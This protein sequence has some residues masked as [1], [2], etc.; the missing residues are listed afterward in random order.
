[1]ICTTI[2]AE[3]TEDAVKAMKK[4]SKLT[5]LIEL[6]IDYIQDINKKNLK[7]LLNKKNKPIIVTNRK[8]YEMEKFKG[9]EKKRIGL[10]EE[11]IKLKADYIDIEYSANKQLLKK[12]I[13]NKGKTKIIV[14]YHNFKN[15]P[16]NLHDIF[17]KI[18][19]LN[20]DIIKIVAFAN[21]INDNFKIFELLKKTKN[22]KIIAFCMGSYGK[23]SRIL[24]LKYNSFLTYSS[25]EQQKK[26]ESCQLTLNE[27]LN[28]YNTKKINKNTQV[29]GLIGNPLE[30][31]PSHLIHNAG[32]KK[33]K[34]NNI[35]VKFKVDNLN[36]FIKN[37]RKFKIKGASITIPH[38]VAVMKHLDSIDNT[39]KKIGAVNTIVNKN[40]KLK[41]YNTDCYGAITVIKNKTE[42]KNKKI[43]VLGAGGTARAVVYGLTQ[44]KGIITILNRT[45][46]KA[47]KL[48]EEFNC[49]Y[50][51]LNNFKNIETDILVN[52]TSVGMSPD[53]GR[54]LIPKRFLKNMV[55]FDA[56]FNPHKTKL[57]KDSESNNCKVI[58][59]IE[60]LIHQAAIQF[61]LWTNQ[62]M[63]INVMR[64]PIINRLNNE[65]NK[66]DR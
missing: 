7:R 35:Y 56:V 11:S 32:F 65:K 41:G 28:D 27:L 43:T 54:S 22:K 23:I 4:A 49:N 37:F 18:K 20:P 51:S 6:R 63:P 1:M 62:E 21:S 33:L 48:A 58:P 2:V 66:H 34:L 8:K 36:E 44:E 52:T 40:N 26:A 53:I 16:N 12:I 57:I 10:L 30:H 25:Y 60:M 42:I 38:K 55:V 5:D 59:G 15:T 39:A 29:Y 47:K 61:K 46:E 9:S 50:D 24:C 17:N 31:S 64:N 14:S 3:N 45:K 19:K 13:K